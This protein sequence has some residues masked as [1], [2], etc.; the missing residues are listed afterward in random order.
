MAQ[1]SRRRQPCHAP[2]TGPVNGPLFPRPASR[3]THHA[4][5]IPPLAGGPIIQT[6]PTTGQPALGPALVVTPAGNVHRSPF[7][8]R[9]LFHPL[10]GDKNCRVGKVMPLAAFSFLLFSRRPVV[11]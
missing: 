2:E 6:R 8:F 5:R 10:W 1:P 9:G 4:S 3:L 11:P 7:L